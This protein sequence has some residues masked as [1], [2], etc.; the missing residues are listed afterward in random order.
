V[1]SSCTDTSAELEFL[2]HWYR[3]VGTLTTSNWARIEVV[4]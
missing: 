2:A 4:M 1:N 3:G